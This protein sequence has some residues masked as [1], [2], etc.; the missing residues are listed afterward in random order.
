MRKPILAIVGRPNTGKSTL[1]NALA[2]KR[3]AIVGPNPGVTRDRIMTDADWAGHDFV[4]IDTGGIETGSKDSLQ[5]LMHQQADV[6]IEM[7]DVICFVTDINMGLSDIDF[8]IA[9]RLRK[10]GKPIVCAVNKIDVPGYPPPEFYT[11]YELGFSDTIPIS[12]THKL[13]LSELLDAV[14]K[15]FP[16]PLNEAGDFEH[17]PVAILGRPNAGK[18]SLANKLLGE[19]RSIVSDIPG[20]TRDSLDSDIEHK[21]QIYRFIDT[22]GLRRKSRIDDSIEYVSTLRTQKAVERCEIALILIDAE[23]GLTSQDTKVAGLAHQAG[24]AS[25][26]VINKWDL[27]NQSA[28]YCKDYEQ[29]VRLRFN[30]MTYA[31]I[32]FMSA[33]T[34][35]GLDELWLTIEKVHEA[36]HRRMPTSMLNDVIADAIVM[37]PAPQHKGRQ[38]KIYYATMTEVAPPTI[39]FFIN[40]IKLL[41]FSYERYLENRLRENFDFQGTPLIFRWKGKAARDESKSVVTPD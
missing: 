15:H 26:F 1:F 30:F 29:S 7:A 2:G 3:L 4:L 9:Q 35:E 38:L 5:D 11:F 18:S 8:D 34:G 17:I 33:K 22:A 40:D 31:P 14:I 25:I 10:S 13:G 28:Q 12:A 37:H 6:A 36:Y 32:L 19:E 20:T 16:E 24:K 27:M 39:L 21:G 23:E 41:H